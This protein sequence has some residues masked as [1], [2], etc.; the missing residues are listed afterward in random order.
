MVV[1]TQETASAALVVRS[2]R[3]LHIG[4]RVE[5]RGPAGVPAGKGAPAE[6]RTAA[7]PR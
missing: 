4:D 2:M 5:M 3:E 7:E 6:S 1:D